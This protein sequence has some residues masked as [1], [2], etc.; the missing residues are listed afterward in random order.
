MKKILIIFVSFVLV[1][2]LFALDF[3][4]YVT[5]AY[6]FGHFTERADSAQTEVSSHAIDL[7]VASYFGGNWGIYLN[8]GCYFP[9]KVSV[10]SGGTTATVTSSDWDYS[11]II[12]AIIGPTFK[13]SITDNLELLTSAGF[14]F[15]Q[16]SLRST[17]VAMLNYS[18]GIGGDFGIRYLPTKNLYLTGGCLFS[19]DFYVDGKTTISGQ[20]TTET[21]DSYNFGSFRPYIGIGLTYTN[22]LK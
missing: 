8:T 19:H 17:Y 5:G 16:Y 6:S 18:F 12:S 4:S 1:A 2:N 15:A 20:G 14:H 10:T 21:S 3:K 22:T 13:Y 7:S 11:M 9:S